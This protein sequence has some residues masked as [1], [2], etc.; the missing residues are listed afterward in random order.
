MIM[1]IL[2]FTFIIT[3]TLS[4]ATQKSIGYVFPKSVEDKVNVYIEQALSNNPKAKFYLTLSKSEADLYL[5]QISE[6][7]NK[8][9]EITSG[10]LKKGNRYSI[11]ANK[12]IPVVNSLDLSYIDLGRSV[13][14]GIIRKSILNHDYGFYFSYHGNIIRELK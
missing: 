12:R 1:K 14:G 9:N 2:I 7:S 3:A 4:C 11:I 6:A 8:S 5:I 13:R 10:L